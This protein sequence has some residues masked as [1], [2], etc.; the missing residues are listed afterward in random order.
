MLY[1]HTKKFPSILT[2]NISLLHAALALHTDSQSVNYWHHHLLNL[3]T[4]RS[5]GA[6]VTSDTSNFKSGQHKADENGL[7][8]ELARGVL[9][10]K[11]TGWEATYQYVASHG[12]ESIYGLSDPLNF[13]RVFLG[14]NREGGRVPDLVLDGED[15]RELREFASR[16][17]GSYHDLVV[18]L[19]LYWQL[20]EFLNPQR[21][22]RKRYLF[23]RRST[24]EPHSQGSQKNSGRFVLGRPPKTGPAEP[25]SYTTSL[26]ATLEGVVDCRESAFFLAGILTLLQQQKFWNLVDLGKYEDACK[27]AEYRVEIASLNIYTDALCSVRAFPSGQGPS[28]WVVPSNTRR[29]TDSQL[30]SS[31]KYLARHRLGRWWVLLENHHVVTVARGGKITT[32]CPMYNAMAQQ[33]SDPDHQC[34]YV[35]DGDSVDNGDEVFF[36]ANRCYPAT[37]LMGIRQPAFWRCNVENAS[38]ATRRLRYG[39]PCP[40]RWN[41]G[42]IDEVILAQRR[43]FEHHQRR[44]QKDPIHPSWRWLQSADYA[45]IPRIT[46]PLEPIFFR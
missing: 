45:D 14:N 20:F 42:S 32:W 39:V 33:L 9:H 1:E 29:P 37:D 22:F 4:D 30:P 19:Q 18:A 5:K 41:Q 12:G 13:G 3:V 8:E 11:S 35:L 17:C 28:S 15:L 7:Y 21:P 34:R 24:G 27:L 31:Q 26:M 2:S 16:Y 36:G 46:H 23:E 40:Q 38:D 44:T 10:A 6:P 43:A 25:I